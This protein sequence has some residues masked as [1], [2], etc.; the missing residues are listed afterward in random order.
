MLWPPLGWGAGCLLPRDRRL[1]Q[2]GAPSLH[3][4]IRLLGA[5]F[6]KRRGGESGGGQR[7]GRSV[8]AGGRRGGA[9]AEPGWVPVPRAARTR[10]PR[11]RRG[12]GGAR[13]PMARGAAAGAVQEHSAADSQT[14][15]LRPH[16]RGI[17]EPSRPGPRPP[18]PRCERTW[19][20]NEQAG[21][22]SWPLSPPPPPPPRCSSRSAPGAL[23]AACLA[24]LLVAAGLFHSRRRA[25]EEGYPAAALVRAL[26]A[27]RLHCRGLSVRLTGCGKDAGDSQSRAVAAQA[28]G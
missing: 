25:G 1:T 5:G 21:A 15:Q 7:K 11:R 4:F 28:R 3:R 24:G 20:Q 16:P 9:G 19:Q 12:G 2:E 18:D 13:W 8:G 26:A 10:S 14:L 17:P 6:G 23:G 22:G 27:C